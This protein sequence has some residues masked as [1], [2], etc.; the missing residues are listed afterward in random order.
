MNT[1]SFLHLLTLHGHDGDEMCLENIQDEM[2]KG[3][4]PL[5]ACYKNYVKPEQVKMLKPED[6]KALVKEG[7][8]VWCK[9][10]F[11]SLKCGMPVLNG[12][13]VMPSELRA[14][15]LDAMIIVK[16]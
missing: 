4:L 13:I 2:K 16:K 15:C 10:G 9:E 5:A 8:T 12:E 11:F 14:L 1:K 7:K 3:V 6:V